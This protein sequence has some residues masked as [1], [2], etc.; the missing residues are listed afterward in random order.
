[1]WSYLK[2][3][4]RKSTDPIISKTLRKQKGN[5]PHLK[6][7]E[8]GARFGILLASVLLITYFMPA[9]GLFSFDVKEGDPW[10]HNPLIATTKFNIYMSDSLLQA[11]KDSLIREFEPYYKAQPHAKDSVKASLSR[12]VRRLMQENSRY[13]TALVSPYV[14]ELTRQVDSVYSH[15][16]MSQTSYDSLTQHNTSYIRVVDNNIATRTPMTDVLNIQRA[17]KKMMEIAADDTEPFDTL[18]QQFLSALNLDTLLK[19]NIVY[20]A[21]KSNIELNSNIDSLSPDIGLVLQNEKIIDRGEIVTKET[22]QKL[23]AY[24][25]TMDEKTAHERPI[26]KIIGQFLLVFLILTV[27]NSFLYI[28]RRDYFMN[29]RAYTMLFTLIVVFSAISSTLIA[30]SL[31]HVFII[32]FCMIPI[33]IRVFMDSRTA[34]V[35]HLGTVTIASLSMMASPHEFLILQVVAGMVAVQS[36]RQ[37]TERSQIVSTMVVL[38]LTLLATHF[39]YELTQVTAFNTSHFDKYPYYWLGI[40]GL[41]LLFAYPLFWVME[42]AF[43]FTSEVTLVELSN[44]NTPLLQKL[45]EAAP[46]TFQH[47]IQV[48]T[49]AAEIA[50]KINANVQLVRTGALYHDIGKLSRPAFFTENQSGKNPHE[51]IS[52]IKSAE[53][54]ISHVTE[55]IKLAEHYDIPDVIKRFILTHHGKGKVKYF[56]ITYKN[57]HPDVE[58]DEEKFTYP[59]PN[60]ESKEEAILMMADSVEAASRSLSEYTEESISNLVDRIISTQVDE[61]YFDESD[62]SFKDIQIAKTALKERLK[63]IYH[64]R[65]T[66]PELKTEE[67]ESEQKDNK[68]TSTSTRNKN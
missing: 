48:A 64:T 6:K 14:S 26:N 66:Y 11:K 45:M 5:T 42:K 34:F 24:K 43:G 7:R 47:S 15:G 65:I 51:R 32:P 4:F 63:T 28:F 30:H 9:P 23:Q 21:T 16:V 2:H 54:I 59:G 17:Y 61:G 57:A 56:Y 55:G 49:L 20:D 67:S 58:I 38:T 13:S 39:C 10:H 52:P 19:E 68:E 35:F 22:L 12:A 41:L 50:G 53:V 25:K 8:W 37:M 36:L 44:T 62:I 31:L 29:F 33:I 27:L 3:L 1:M 40:S 46:G 60:P 18:C